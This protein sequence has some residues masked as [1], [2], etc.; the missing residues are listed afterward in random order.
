LYDVAYSCCY[1]NEDWRRLAGDLAA[2]KQDWPVNHARRIYK[3]I[4]DNKKYLQ[5]RALKMEYGAD[6]HDLATFY[7]EDGEKDKAIKIAQDGLKQGKGRM[8][9]LRRFLSDRSQETGD[10][11][12]YLQLQFD[13]TV[14]Q[15]TFTKYQAFKKL[16]SKDE[17]G[18]YEQ[19]I[20]QC[21]NRAWDTEKLKIFMHRKEYDKALAILLKTRYP[22][23]S[24]CSKY[25]LLTAAKLETRFP[26]KILGFY[27]SG[28][29]NLNHSLTRKEYA[30]KA[31]RM[32]KVR[33]MYVDIMNTPKKWI[34]FARKVKL[35]N[36]RRPAFQEEFGKAVPGWE[37]L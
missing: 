22:H 34:R 32:K 25:E 31:K 35:D 9:E 37:A 6:Y 26:D 8:D 1:D 16:C 30:R 27:L 7:W 17:W 14:D 24:F 3:R 19:D 29:G 5:L 21:L 10:R 20:L 12:G 11:K 23:N 33:H 18:S 36:K 13:Q 15:L 4:G 2:L 28:L